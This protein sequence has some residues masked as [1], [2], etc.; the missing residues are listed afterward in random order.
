MQFIQFIWQC[1]QP[2][3]PSILCSLLRCQFQAVF[4]QYRNNIK[5]QSLTDFYVHKK[6]KLSLERKS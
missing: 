3:L 5:C 1:C 6:D 4:L 2:D